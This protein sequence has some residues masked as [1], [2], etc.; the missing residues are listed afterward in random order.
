MRHYICEFVLPFDEFTA[1][2]DAG[3]TTSVQSLVP[4]RV[5]TATFLRSA[6]RGPAP[7]CSQEVC[8][9]LKRTA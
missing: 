9:V 2:A 7:P 4:Y 3:E 8:L 5:S 6:F 1:V